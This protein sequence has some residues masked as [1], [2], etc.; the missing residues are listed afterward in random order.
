MLKRLNA[1]HQAAVSYVAVGVAVVLLTILY[2]PGAHYRSGFWPL[3]AGVV[4]LLVLARFVWKGVRWLTVTLSVL[5]LVRFGWMVYSFVNFADE[6]T[7]WVYMVNAIL[8]LSIVYMLAR[9][10]WR[11]DPVA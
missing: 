9:A 3:I 10:S 4:V 7:S 1:Y 6:E 8:M 5:S 11:P 2:I